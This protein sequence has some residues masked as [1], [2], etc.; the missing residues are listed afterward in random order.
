VV[1][2]SGQGYR[3]KVKRTLGEEIL[4][5]RET[6]QHPTRAREAVAPT[7][8]ALHHVLPASRSRAGGAGACGDRT[9]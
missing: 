5:Q 1:A 3:T 9:A 6:P 2:R 8:A 4:S 7:G